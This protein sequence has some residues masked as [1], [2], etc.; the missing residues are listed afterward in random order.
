V[1]SQPSPIFNSNT[2]G[3]GGITQEFFLSPVHPGAL[4]WASVQSLRFR[5][6]PILFLDREKCCSVPRPSC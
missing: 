1:I 4:I 6:R 2:N 3:I 5:P